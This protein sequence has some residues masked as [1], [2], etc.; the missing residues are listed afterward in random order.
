[1]KQLI[2]EHIENIIQVSFK[3]G[4]NECPVIGPFTEFSVWLNIRYLV[5]YLLSNI[6]YLAGKEPVII[7]SFMGNSLVMEL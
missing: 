1:M 2:F 3:L 7:Y 5:K 6:K 4:Y